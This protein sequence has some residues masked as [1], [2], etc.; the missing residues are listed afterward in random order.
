MNKE[1]AAIKSIRV[2][3]KNNGNNNSPRKCKSPQNNNNVQ[4]MGDDDN[5]GDDAKMVEN[6]GINLLVNFFL[7]RPE[8][9]C[10]R[11]PMGRLTTTR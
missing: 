3:T 6:L 1:P 9:S 8:R 10:K 2:N 7:S 5:D 4:Q 11:L